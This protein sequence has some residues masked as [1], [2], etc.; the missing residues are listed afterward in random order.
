MHTATPRECFALK[1]LLSRCKFEKREEEEEEKKK[2][3]FNNAQC[4]T[5]QSNM[6]F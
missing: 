1:I 5:A 4:E 2:P 6:H 3:V